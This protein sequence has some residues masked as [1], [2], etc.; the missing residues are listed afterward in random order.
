[1]SYT[2][3]SVLARSVSVSEV[4]DIVELLGYRRVRDGLKIPNRVAEYFWLDYDD[5]RSWYGVELGIYKSPRGP[6][7]ISTRSTVSRSYWDLKHQNRT[8]KLLRDLFGGHFVTD[9]GR[10]RYWRPEEPPPSPISSGCYLSR[11]RLH[12]NL[13]R[14]HVYLMSRDSRGETAGRVPSGLAIVDQ[15]NPRLI[16]NN[17]LLPYLI[18][19]W[20]EYFRSMFIACLKYTKQR[21]GALK[22]AKL[23]HAHLEELATGTAQVEEAVASHFYF[24]RPSAIAEC[25]KL[26]DPKLDLAAPLRKPYRRRKVK[27]FDS[28]EAL[29]EIRNEIVHSGRIDL[30]LTDQKLNTLVADL[31][32][33]ADRAYHYIGAHF[34]FAP[35][36]VY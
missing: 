16:S 2:S 11:W 14:A 34:G 7:K 32:V 31:V 18:A 6:V 5:Y 24:Q 1:M 33:C 15:Y 12:N 21:E 9:A 29:V 20:E 26:L 23:S 22:R 17:L 35:I 19:V 30:T 25:F 36:E 8:L 13:G 10:N 4:R 28:M 27:L 3:E